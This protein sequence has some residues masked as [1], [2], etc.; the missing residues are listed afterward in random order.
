MCDKKI[1]SNE[2]IFL[3]CKQCIPSGGFTIATISCNILVWH[4]IKR[5]SHKKERCYRLVD[6]TMYIQLRKQTMLT[7]TPA[8]NIPVVDAH[9]DA[10]F[11]SKLIAVINALIQQYGNAAMQI[12]KNLR[13]PTK[14]KRNAIGEVIEPTREC[15]PCDHYPL[16]TSNL[17]NPDM[18]RVGPKGDWLI[19]F[20]NALCCANFPSE[21]IQ[22]VEASFLSLSSLTKNEENKLTQPLIGFTRLA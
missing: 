12:T 7:E 13:G 1:R 20:G 22:W 18:V 8:G 21:F 9:T 17:L 3:S 15:T 11:Q 2:R 6:T 5:G 10:S 14:L 19:T 16:K 4:L